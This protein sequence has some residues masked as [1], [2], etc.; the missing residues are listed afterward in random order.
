MV[1]RALDRAKLRIRR[2]DRIT[3]YWPVGIYAVSVAPLFFSLTWFS[4]IDANVEFVK[5]AWGVIASVAA[6]S[7]AVAF[8]AIQGTQ[9]SDWRLTIREFISEAKIA[10]FI[11]INVAA[12]LVDWAVLLDFG[13][14][15]PDGWAGRWAA[16]TAGVAILTPAILFER[17]VTS[18]DP[19]RLQRSIQRRVIRAVT[20]S[21]RTEI[22]QRLAL[23]ITRE[24]AK[25]HDV[26]MSGFLFEPDQ[27]PA[28]RS[29]RSGVI[30]DIKLRK[31]CSTIQKLRKDIPSARVKIGVYV[32]RVI[33]S[34]EPIV[35]LPHDVTSEA[36][37]RFEPC[38]KIAHSNNRNDLD[39]ELKRLR[40]G[41]LAAIRDGQSDQHEQ[42]AELY[43]ELLLTYPRAWNEYGE[44][45]DQ[46]AAKGLDPFQ[47]PQT[48]RITDDLREQFEQALNADHREIIE[49]LKSLLTRLMLSSVE[50]S[51]HGLLSTLLGLSAQAQHVAQRLE[52]SSLADDARI[53][54]RDLPFFVLEHGVDRTLR[55]ERSTD[56]QK[57]T[58]TEFANLLFTEIRNTAKRLIDEG[59]F[60]EAEEVVRIWSGSLSQ[61][62]INTDEID[63]QLEMARLQHPDGSPEVEGLIEEQRRVQKLTDLRVALLDQR[64]KHIFEVAAWTFRILE[65]NDSP[66]AKQLFA[67]LIGQVGGASDR[68]SAARQLLNTDT[69]LS[70]WI[71]FSLPTRQAHFIGTDG[72]VLRTLALGLLMVAPTNGNRI[73]FPTEEWL[74][75]RAQVLREAIER[76]LSEW[77]EWTPI[78]PNENI[79]AEPRHEDAAP[80]SAELDANLYRRKRAEAVLHGLS[81][82]IEKFQSSERDTLVQAV[83]SQQ[84]IDWFLTLLDKGVTSSRFAD[85]LTDGVAELPVGQ[86]VEPRYRSGPYQWV[87]KDWFLEGCNVVNVDDVAQ[88]LGA[89]V[90]QGEAEILFSAIRQAQSIE[91]VGGD[92]TTDLNSAI[93]L[94]RARSFRPTAIIGPINWR[95]WQEIGIQRNDTAGFLPAGVGERMAH[96]VEG[97]IGDVLIIESSEWP[98]DHIVVLDFPAHIE[99]QRGIYEDGSTLRRQLQFFDPEAARALAEENPRMMA[100]EER[101]SLEARVEEIRTQALLRVERAVSTRTKDAKAAV[102]IPIPADIRREG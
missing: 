21:V 47:L 61:W 57:A 23:N 95:L 79:A 80:E 73:V 81:T 27:E 9:S 2:F 44:R 43:G 13:H 92:I 39:T 30:R 33:P 56:D 35:V 71:L 8:F 64:R 75:A 1:L 5:S 53:S 40:Q 91:T 18:M 76:F 70:N 46:N 26:S 87:P 60:A 65:K 72:L 4:C 97:H 55:R 98:N 63:W 66:D 52:N 36:Q 67:F 37:E 100:S 25:S 62:N 74:V 102:S 41:A 90:G 31:L 34:D 7:F 88:D 24:F 11:H 38:F 28:V 19:A 42:W 77:D 29:K 99:L 84:R 22:E 68:I 94:L 101:I 93:A 96:W 59:R 69:A 48:G 58:A 89:L 85:L 54:L 86:L 51:A 12:L 45:F 3:R 17:A 83:P 14:G 6:L 20:D 78:L 16:I 15:G 10:L 82:A 49:S 32:G 50:L